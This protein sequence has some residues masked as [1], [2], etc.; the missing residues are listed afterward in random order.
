MMEV[1]ALVSDF[2]NICWVSRLILLG[3]ARAWERALYPRLLHF[4]GGWKTFWKWRTVV[5]DS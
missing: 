2:K 5:S 1:K 3:A 4:I